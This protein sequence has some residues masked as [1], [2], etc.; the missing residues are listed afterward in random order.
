MNKGPNND[1]KIS[2]V[3]SPKDFFSDIVQ[4]AISARKMS[5]F[6]LAQNYLVS[7]LESYIHTKNLFDTQAENGKLSRDTLAETFLKAQTANT[8]VKIELL[9]KLGDVS[10]YVSGFFADSLSRKVVDVDY[11]VDMGE[12]AYGV[13]AGEI[14]EDT[15]KK[16]F[17][18]FSK[19]F[20]EYV[21]ILTTISQKSLVQ[22]DESILRLYEKYLKTGSE[23]ARETL[24]EKGIVTIPFDKD[25]KSFAQ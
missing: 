1:K 5:T 21:D 8:T 10:L 18:D 23:L 4:E 15:S 22:N 17:K 19:R 12:T 9:K 16:V 7:I 20:L 13:L 14:K 6:P 25:K 24:E 2:F 3:M 11:Y